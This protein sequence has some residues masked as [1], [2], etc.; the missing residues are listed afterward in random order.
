[1][2]ERQTHQL[3]G[4]AGATLCE[5]KSRLAHHIYQKT[6]KKAGFFVFSRFFEHIAGFMI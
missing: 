4:L 3:E 5:F 6:R 2:A 1:V